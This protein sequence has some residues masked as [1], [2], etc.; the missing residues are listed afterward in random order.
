[1]PAVEERRR[2]PV[3]AWRRGGRMPAQA[4]VDG[5][6]PG[7]G[8]SPGLAAGLGRTGGNAAR[9]RIGGN[10]RA[11]RARRRRGWVPAPDTDAPQRGEGSA[12][13]DGRGHPPPRARSSAPPSSASTG[14]A[15]PRPPWRGAA[16]PSIAVGDTEDV[17]SHLD[18]GTEVIDG[19]RLDR[20]AGPRRLAHPPVPRHPAHPGRRPALGPDDRRGPR[21]PPRRGRS[22]PAR[23]V[24]ARALGR[25][26]G[27][28]RG[29]HPRRPD[30]RGRR[31]PAGRSSTSSTDHTALASAEALRRAGVDGPREFTENAEVVCEADGRP[32][33]ALLELGAMSARPRC[34]SRVDPGRAARRLRGHAAGLNAVGLTGAHVM[35]GEPGAPRRR[36]RARGAGRADA[37]DGRPDALRAVDHRGGDPGAAGR[38]GRARALWRAGTAKFF[39]DGVIESGT[40]WQLE[41]GPGGDQRRA[42]LDRPRPLPRPRA[43]RDRGRLLVHVAR[44]GGRGRALGARRL[45]GGRAAAPGMHRIEH[46]E[47]LLDDDLPRFAGLGRRRLDAAAAHGR[48]STGRARTR[49]S[50]ASRPGGVERGWR[51]ADIARTGAVLALGSDWMV[52]DYDPRVGMGWAR[53]RREPGVPGRTPYLPEQALSPA[54]TLA[55][56][57]TCPAAITGDG[58]RA[59]RLAPGSQRRHHGPRREPAGGPARRA[60]GRPGAAHGRRRGDRAPRSVTAAANADAFSEPSPVARS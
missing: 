33:G 1:M 2:Q 21:P 17:R 36:A 51:S 60:P 20:D 55:G 41:P 56:Y 46:I 39:L 47:T 52:A 43:A 58:D 3:S 25:L 48:E 34:R 18:G 29:R 12:P 11:E 13:P 7:A 9:R 4:D 8:L 5:I 16:T 31:R 30:R 53:L 23:R 49:G 42:V 32:T 59:G 35:L 27:V 24:G 50:T 57:T 6:S 54:R 38:R 15:R 14:I 28:S 37:A 22:D 26:R 44:R 10:G 40:A 45:R 19:S